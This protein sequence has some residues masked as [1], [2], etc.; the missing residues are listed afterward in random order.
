MTGRLTGD[1]RA[2]LSCG[3]SG[4]PC[5]RPSGPTHCPA[6]DDENPSLSVRDDNGRVLVH[7]HTSCSQEAV[8]GALRERGLWPTETR[9]S[10]GGA[11]HVRRDSPSGKRMHWETNGAAGLGGLP[12]KALP[13]YAVADLTDLP[14]GAIVVICEGEPSTDALR[15]RGIPAVGTAT[16]AAAV[17]CDESLSALARFKVR[18]WA[19]NDGPGKSHMQ[20]IAGR[21][22]AL[23]CEDVRIIRWDGA[24]P[25]GDASDWGGSDGEL[26][27]L[28]D[29]AAKIDPPAPI[30][31]LLDAVKDFTT[32]YVILTDSQADAL[33]LWIAH[34]HTIDA[35]EATPYIEITSA[36]KRSGKSRLLETL[37]HVV[38]NPWLTGRTSAAAL[39]RKMGEGVTALIDESD[40]AFKGP[41]EYSEALRGILN[42][43]HRRGG[44][45][46]LVV[47][48]GTAMTCKDFPVFGA[49]A[50]AGIGRLPDTVADRSITIQLKRRAPNEQVARQRYR[51]AKEEGEPLRDRLS[52]WSLTISDVLSAG[53]PDIPA[54]LDDRA[55]DGWEPLLAIADRAGGTWPKRARVAAK[56]LSCGEDREDASLGVRLL[57]DIQ[58][59]I[60][61]MER[62]TIRELVQKL[63][64]IEDAPWG[65]LNGKPL[66]GRRLGWRLRQFGVKAKPIR[67]GDKTPKGYDAE[68]FEDAFTR[69]SLTPEKRE[70]RVERETAGR[71]DVS[72]C[73]FVPLISGVSGERCMVCGSV[74]ISG[75]TPDGE[76][77]CAGHYPLP[78]DG[79]LTRAAVG[80]GLK[81]IARRPAFNLCCTDD[82]RPPDD[83]RKAV[84]R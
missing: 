36:E 8:I 57:T 39:V 42:N 24:P 70:T 72:L 32:K 53:R 76:Q 28:L 58:A 37:Q 65:D 27:D 7:C 20:I 75:Y 25:K 38:A 55:A 45:A 34:T 69:Y 80:L 23:G 22:L 60:A 77:R 9:W 64:A 35:A 41:S 31:E 10:V 54:E 59:T 52:S 13:L 17:P 6:H 71:N 61:G 78:G 49:K 62:I 68:Q 47:G 18:L 83:F 44:C 19:D 11:E 51:D 48:Q 73:P 3:R 74:E 33:A 56:S 82:A 4:C 40:A 79:H 1:I 81:V 63:T 5:S 14:A 67:V 26:V 16:G 66:D 21:L 12:V 43:G 2:A 15:A 30:A 50:I 84:T 46:T 29:S